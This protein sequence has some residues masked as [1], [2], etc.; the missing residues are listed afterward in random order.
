MGILNSVMGQ[1]FPGS[2]GHPNLV[3]FL[4][5]VQD[6]GGFPALLTRFKALEEGGLTAANLTSEHISSLFS[7][8]ELSSI[9]QRMGISQQDVIDWISAH[10][11]AVLQHLSPEIHQLGG[12]NM[13]DMA[14]SILRE[15]LK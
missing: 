5:W 13:L 11:P 15:R 14:L 7:E 4:S 6:E 2:E 12:N 10:L 1:L 3:A 9:A 8:G